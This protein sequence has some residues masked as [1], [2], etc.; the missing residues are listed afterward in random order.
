MAINESSGINSTAPLLDNAYPKNH[1]A[2][3]ETTITKTSSQNDNTPIKLV[4]QDSV[5]ISLNGTTQKMFSTVQSANSDINVVAKSVREANATLVTVTGHINGMKAALDKIVKNFPPFTADSKERAELL[6]SYRAIR[7]EI[8][9]MTFPPPL[10]ALQDTLDDIPV[11]A[12]DGQVGD[13]LKS[14][15]T[16]AGQIEDARGKLAKSST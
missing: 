6:M 13:A 7:K 9:K 4:N 14:V 8:E 5:A 16:A 12:T 10:P 15:E 2:S 11:N 3:D 1:R